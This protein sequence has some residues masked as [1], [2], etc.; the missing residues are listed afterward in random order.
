LRV[1]C[2]LLLHLRLHLNTSLR[3]ARRPVRPPLQPMAGHGLF[4]STVSP[5]RRRPNQADARHKAES[6][7]H[8][9]LASR[10]EG[11]FPVR[12]PANATTQDAHVSPGF[13]E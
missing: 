11:W 4:C 2:S 8:I 3:G 7:W 1:L 12:E 10:G 13:S 5:T 6:K 9:G